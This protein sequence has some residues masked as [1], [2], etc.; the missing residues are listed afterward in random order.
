M[1]GM[2]KPASDIELFTVESVP[3]ERYL[4]AVIFWARHADFAEAE[5]AA[6]AGLR[7]QAAELG[8]NAI[9]GLR[10]ETTQELYIDSRTKALSFGPETTSAAM[11]R[12]YVSGTAALV[13]DR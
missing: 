4:G 9:I 8:A 12:V 3:V 11:N 2:A 10:V 5:R 6:F 7:G 13:S 1:I